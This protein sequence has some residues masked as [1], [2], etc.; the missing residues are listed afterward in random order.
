MPESIPYSREFINTAISE[1]ASHDAEKRRRGAASLFQAGC[2]DAKAV[3]EE[4]LQDEE[5]VKLIVVGGGNSGKAGHAVELG[6]ARLTVGV[7]VR[8]ET[9]A[10]IRQACGN[11]RLADVPPEQQAQEFE[12][13]FSGQVAL[14]VL[15]S[16]APDGA[17]PLA[18][19]LRKFGEGIQ[20]VEIEVSSVD[21]GSQILQTKFGL[22][23][24][25]PETRIGADGTR[26]NFFLA[27]AKSGKKVLIELVEK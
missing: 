5:F 19:Y 17:A 8:P 22:K 9:F 1:L 13:E 27:T 2:A 18:S 26:V 11:P 7:A 6:E 20:Q 14:D 16:S 24:A 10:S 15:T 3:I 4:W 23:A 12:L 21:Q 25:Y